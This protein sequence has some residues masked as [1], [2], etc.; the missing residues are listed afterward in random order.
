MEFVGNDR[1]KEI[2]EFIGAGDG[3]IESDWDKKNLQDVQ[4]KEVMIVKDWIK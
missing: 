4:I 1:V 3:V 2:W